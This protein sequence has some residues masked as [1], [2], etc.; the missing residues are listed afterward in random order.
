MKSMSTFAK[1][2]VNKSFFSVFSMERCKY[3]DKCY[4]ENKEHFERY[5]HPGDDL[6]SL[7]SSKS[8]SSN[9]SSTNGAGTAS[10]AGRSGVSSAVTRPSA[11]SSVVPKRSSAPSSDT[12]KPLS[13]KVKLG[14]S[15]PSPS[16]ANK[17]GSGSRSGKRDISSSPEEG[18]CFNL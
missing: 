15:V 18:N 6:T 11:P 5:L 2:C 8:S 17:P 12:H 4:R 3:W 9:T 1:E 16:M 14:R 13:S 7:K 10:S